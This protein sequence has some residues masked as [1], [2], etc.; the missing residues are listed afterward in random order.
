MARFLPDWNRARVFCEG[1]AERKTLNPVAGLTLGV[2]E[3]ALAIQARLGMILAQHGDGGN[4]DIQY[5]N[6]KLFQSELLS[7]SNGSFT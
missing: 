4:L 3:T 6:H 1:R 2:V 5:G 7:L